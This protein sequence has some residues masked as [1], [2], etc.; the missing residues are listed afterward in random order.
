MR[1]RTRNAAA[2]PTSAWERPDAET[3]VTALEIAA[4]G[5]PPAPAPPTTR[6]RFAVPRRG[7][8]QVTDL[9]PIGA[10]SVRQRR[11]ITRRLGGLWSPPAFS[12][13]L[14]GVS[15]LVGGLLLLAMI[16]LFVLV[17]VTMG[18]S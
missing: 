13:G 5:L 2:E 17:F 8:R 1:R 9:P 14:V 7:P 16:A 11:V 15:M 18:S 4:G 3:A 6:R 10:S 12:A